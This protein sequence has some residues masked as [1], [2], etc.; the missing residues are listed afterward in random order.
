M[1]EIR[2]HQGD[3]CTLNVQAIVNAANS[4]LLGGAGVDGAIHRAAGP[5]LLSHCKTLGGCATGE[6]VIT[7]G[8]RL[9]ARHIIHT[10]GP[11]WQGGSN[12]EAEL[13]RHCYQNAMRLAEENHLDSIAFPAISCGAHG[14]PL[15]EASRVAIHG[16][17]DSLRH[18]ASIETV[19]FCCVDDTTVMAYQTAL[20]CRTL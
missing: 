3:I 14:F 18:C 20:A 13:L 2:V 11:V 10:V 8:F 7:P 9:P 6:A 4:A 5:E 1:T 16:V 19:L 12:H 15:E 17:C